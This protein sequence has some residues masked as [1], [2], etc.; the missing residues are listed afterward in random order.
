MD[1]GATNKKSISLFGLIMIGIGSIFGSGWLFGAGSAAAV[2]GP[3]AIV[4][5]CLGANSWG[6]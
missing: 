3:A 6:S 5:W 1:M 2:A 4:A